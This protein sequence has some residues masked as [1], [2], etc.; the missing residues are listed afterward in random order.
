[1]S[2][3]P[4]YTDPKVV[5]DLRKAAEDS[6]NDYKAIVTF[7]FYGGMDSSNILVPTGSNPNISKYEELRKEGIRLEQ[8][9]IGFVLNNNDNLSVTANGSWGLHPSLTY[10]EDLWNDGDLV[11]FLNAGILREP[12]TKDDYVLNPNRYAPNSLFAHNVQQELWQTVEVSQVSTGTG[13]L[14]RTSNLFD[15]YYADKSQDPIYNEGRVVPSS[16]FSLTG[17]DFQSK[18]YPPLSSVNF[19]PTLFTDANSRFAFNNNDVESVSASLRHDPEASNPVVRSTNRIVDSFIEIYNDSI[20]VQQAT[21]ENIFDWNADPNLT[22]SEKDDINAIFDSNQDQ[23]YAAATALGFVVSARPIFQ[24]ETIAKILYSSKQ[25]GYNQRRQ[26]IFSAYGGWDHHAQLRAQHDKKLL[27]INYAIKALV[28]FAKH[29]KVNM[30]DNSLVINGETDFNRTL[31][32]NA[33]SGVDHAWG[34]HYFAIG[35]PLNGGIYPPNYMPDYSIEGSN[36]DRSSLGRFIPEVGVDQIYA[37]LLNWFGVPEQHLHLV[38]TSLPKFTN[39]SN[40]NFKF[41]SGNYTLNFI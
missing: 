16:S 10:F 26:T 17:T 36:S 15:P 32:S 21:S 28:E 14:G 27:E 7:F 6:G 18:S 12:T 37:K 34:G 22:Q 31:R 41:A 23:L 29:P 5:S 13:W 8:D 3:P 4:S 24:S 11:F 33:N 38:L 35:G 39:G 30:F 19:P 25:P 40:L 1:M 9:E 2:Q 20:D